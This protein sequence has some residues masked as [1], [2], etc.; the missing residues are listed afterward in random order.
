[1]VNTRFKVA[2]VQSEETYSTGTERIRKTEYIVPASATVLA[3]PER[4]K[5]NVVLQC[6]ACHA[7]VVVELRSSR[8]AVRRLA[9]AFGLGLVF[10]L[11]LIIGIIT[12]IGQLQMVGFYTTIVGLIVFGY[13]VSEAF[14]DA[15]I[16]KG[17]TGHFLK[18]PDES[19]Q[20]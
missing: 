16:S 18:T 20:L 3:L 17:S 19:G 1:M 8:W 14:K 10:A 13:G 11:P 9:I 7:P 5:E 6:A 4:G 12:N 15:K 2:H